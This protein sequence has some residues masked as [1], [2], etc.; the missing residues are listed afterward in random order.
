MRLT[1]GTVGA[2]RTESPGLQ[3]LTVRVD[4]DAEESSAVCYPQLCGSC[5]VGDRVLLNTTAVDLGLG[6]GGEHVVVCRIP[7]GRA[8]EGVALEVPGAGH[9]LK[10]RYTPTQVDVGAVEE[11]ESPYHSLMLGADSL[12]GMPVVCCGLHSQLPLA[13]AAVKAAD[14]AL[15]VAYVM[16][17]E[18]ALPLALSRVAAQAK[19]AGLI[20]VTLTAGQAFGGDIEAVNRYSALLAARAVARADVTV[21]AIG[22]GVVGTAT[23]FGHGGVAQAEAVNAAAVLGGKPVVALRVSFADARE[24]HR[25]VSHH[26]LAALRLA[27]APAEVAIPALAEEQAAE[28]ERALEDADAWHTHR[29]AEAPACELPDLRGVEV[30]TMGR[31]PAEDPAFFLAAAAAGEVAARLAGG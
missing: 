6:T 12:S 9:I 8:P 18:A 14:P 27:L 4:G 29:R 15:R 13:A 30:R 31:T 20:D 3:S 16:T 28:V 25:G 5:T 1:W 23:P 21:V 2:V 10:L 26:T 11:Q 19:A 22:P 24:R 7:R 17:D